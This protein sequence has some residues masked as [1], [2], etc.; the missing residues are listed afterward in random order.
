MGAN[1]VGVNNIKIDTNF[2]L[3]SKCFGFS[4]QI[5]N[6]YNFLDLFDFNLEYSEYSIYKLNEG[7][8]KKYI[9]PQILTYC[10]EIIE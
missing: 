1:L 6:L 5:P 3:T 2:H 4:E 7:G 9:L 8:I 10:N